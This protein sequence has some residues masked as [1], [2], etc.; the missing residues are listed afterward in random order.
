MVNIAR[1]Y[2]S[3]FSYLGSFYFGLSPPIVDIKQISGLTD[4]PGSMCF[5]KKPFIPLSLVTL[6]A[7]KG[8]KRAIEKNGV[9][10]LYTHDV[11]F[12]QA[13][14]IQ[15]FVKDFGEILAYASL[16]REQEKLTITTIRSLAE[17]GVS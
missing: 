17:D 9:F 1:K 10:H 2:M 5:N 14:N 13:P 16:Q 3:L 4:I 8:I 15:S 6:K 7:K 11:N 12:G